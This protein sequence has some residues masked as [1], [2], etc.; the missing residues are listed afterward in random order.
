MAASDKNIII[1]PN[2]GGATAEPEIFFG[3]SGNN[4][5]RLKVLDDSTGTLSFEG[6]AGQL[7]SIN[8]SLTS[9]SIFSVND[10]SGIPS[11]DVNADGTVLLAPFG[12]TVGIGTT[13]PTSKLSVAG[14]ISATNIVNGVV[15]GGATLTGDV[16]FT[17][18]SNVTLTP[19]GNTITIASSGG[20]GG[21]TTTAVNTFTA[22]QIFTAGL[23]GNLTG[24]ASTATSAATLTT[25]RSINGT[26][27]NGGSD[28]TTSNWG[29]SRTITIGDTGK[30]VNGS[31]NVSWSFSD[32][33]A[34]STNTANK[35]VLRDG[36][37][38][39]SA[40]T[41]TASLNGNASTA[42]SAATL[43][44]A[45]SINGTSFNGGSDIT[46]ANWG[47]SRTITVGNTGKSVNGSGNVSWSLSEIGA[48]AANAVVSSVV[49]GGATLT[50]N[51]SLTAGSNITLTPSGSTITIASTASGG[52]GVTTTAANTWTALQTFSVGITA[53]GATFGVG[54]VS[55][56]NNQ[57]RDVQLK[58]YY[59]IR[60][61]PTISSGTLTLNLNDSNIF[62]VS[63]NGNITTMTV[64]NVPSGTVATGFTLLLTADGTLRTVT[65]PASFKWPGGSAPS[66]TST[67]GKTDVYSFITLNNGTN[68]YGFV[69]GQNY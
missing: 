51:V 62:D 44:T 37:G 22:T 52:G 21:I 17:A 1:T 5:I 6:S 64:S 24:N 56:Q 31:G 16:S 43:T 45:R 55:M 41:I 10:V 69:G 33:G 30:S 38:N 28:I 13:T 4:P 18:G 42:T 46:T 49:V 27:F 60:A 36:L 12:G 66:V 11:I 58:D 63:L 19:S 34:V 23:S 57:I 9:G 14:T 15:V 29:T 48:P 2:R 20:G 40:G 50:G 3:G 7:F 8:N 68:W 61:A 47:T 65:W 25:A 26:S 32:I 53:Y 67:N 54:G 39:F 59:E 35:I